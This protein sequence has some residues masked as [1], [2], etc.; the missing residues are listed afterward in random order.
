MALTAAT[1]LLFVA[2]GT[3]SAGTTPKHDRDVIRFFSHHPKLAKTKAGTAAAWKLVAHLTVQIRSLQSARLAPT[4]DWATAVRIVQRVYPGSSWWLLSCSASEGGHGIF[5]MNAQ[6][7]QAGGWMQYMQGTF[8]GDFNAA[9]QDL[10]ARG[11][12]VP[13][14]AW[15]WA[16]PLG[17][18][19][20]AGWAY[21]HNRPSGKW[22]GGGC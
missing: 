5:V 3:S 19:V 8:Q 4:D 20:A 7:S 10:H 2:A 1:V 21:S 17:Q 13:A 16:S 14:S 15:S 6:G 22:Q 11:I 9:V 18:A 12:R